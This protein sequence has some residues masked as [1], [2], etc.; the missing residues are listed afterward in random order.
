M[1][2]SN[3]KNTLNILITSYGSP[4]SFEDGSADHLHDRTQGSRYFLQVIVTGDSASSLASHSLKVFQQCMMEKLGTP[5][6][7][8]GH[9]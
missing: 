3:A 4:S 8:C 6:I 1:F 7:R 2:I 9:L 5:D